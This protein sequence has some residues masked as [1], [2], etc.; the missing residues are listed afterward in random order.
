MDSANRVKAISFL[1]FSLSGYKETTYRHPLGGPSFRT[2]LFQEALVEF[3]RPVDLYVLLTETAEKRIPEDAS[4]SNW[5]ELERRLAGK[6]R[7]VPVTRI[8]EALQVEDLWTIFERLTECID[9]GDRVL[10]DITHGFRS[11]PVIALIALSFLRVVKQIEIVGVVYGAFEAK[12]PD[13]DE[14]PVFD[15]T[16]MVSL[17]QW[18]AATDQF[19][20]TGNASGLRSLLPVEMGDLAGNLEAISQGLL[21]L[22]PLD[23]MQSAAE[24]PAHIQN[25]L[26]MVAEK[27]PPFS[28]LLERIQDGYGA[29][30]L[31]NPSEPAQAKVALLRMLCM[32][33]WYAEKGEYVQALSLAREWPP[34][35]LCYHFQVD[36][37]DAGE[38]EDMELL[39]NGGKS[40]SNGSNPSRISRRL[41]EW[42]GVPSGK[43]LRA[44]WAG[45]LALANL[46]NDV[47][48]SGFRHN[49]LGAKDIIARTQE[50]IRELR[51]IAAASGLLG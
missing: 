35:L 49:A 17:L 45:E 2:H 44:L 26:P 31:P 24:L 48:H 43:R 51:A 50:V 28:L 19:L 15:L 6:V 21:L 27:V 39:L 25:V 32:I 4:R 34:S 12:L 10:F 37:L 16:P 14:K 18:T 3:Y 9:D 20:R 33:E 22:R 36:M 30:S 38:R 40:K 7:L 1:G 41:T 29:F 46:R 42:P 13:S 11:F 23:V 5:H 8:P 47:L